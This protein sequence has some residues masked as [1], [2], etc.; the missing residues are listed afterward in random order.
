MRTQTVASYFRVRFFFLS[1]YMSEQ[2]LS[3]T[4]LSNFLLPLGTVCFTLLVL[5][6]V[7]SDG[8]AVQDGGRPA[9]LC[10]MYQ[11]QQRS[12]SQQVRPGEGSGPAAIYRRSGDRQDQEA[13]LLSPHPVCQ[14]HKEVSRFPASLW[15]S[16]KRRKLLRVICV[17]PH[18][19]TQLIYAD[20]YRYY[21]LAFHAHEEPAV[22][23][24]T[25]AAILEKA[26]LENWAMGKTKVK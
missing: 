3:V 20:C 12:P 21:I 15:V 8:P 24:E 18:I 7:L 16:F 10:A 4:L 22:T 5:F 2:F 1:A 14:L 13:G 6:I 25:C 11:T 19:S 17:G 26:K 23:S 9:S